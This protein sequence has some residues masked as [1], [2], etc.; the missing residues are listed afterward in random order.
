MTKRF[1]TFAAAAAFLLVGFS[2]AQAQKVKPTV[3]A[4]SK[5]HLSKADKDAAKAA[6]DAA[7]AQRKAD[8]RAEKSARNELKGQSKWLLKGVKL[9]KQEKASVKAIERRTDVEMKTL[10]KQRKTDEKAGR[11]TAYVTQRLYALRD[12]ERA[13]LRAVL[14]PE[15]QTRFDQNV[16]AFHGKH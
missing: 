1:L 11:P 8:E 9:S 13:D 16:T 10:E 2:S 6:Q 7:K 3:P 4:T 14:T 5:A 15:Q 12:Q